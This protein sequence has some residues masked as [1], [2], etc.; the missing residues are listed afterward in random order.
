MITCNKF[1]C[2]IVGKDTCCYDCKRNKTC[3]NVCLIL[4]ST[5][6][7]KENISKDNILEECIY[8]YDNN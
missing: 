2:E 1:S 5:G 3:A 7:I 6:N 4:D 8:A